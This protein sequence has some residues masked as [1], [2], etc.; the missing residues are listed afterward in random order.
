MLT[1]T[2]L[3]TQFPKTRRNYAKTG[4]IPIEIYNSNMESFR[5]I[6]RRYQ[7]RAIFR[8]PRQEK[9]FTDYTGKVTKRYSDS[10]TRK[11]DATHVV[12]YRK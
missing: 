2:Q 11:A 7:L 8:G 6:K 4:Y 12:L 3:Q 9:V 1:L 5:D 10:M